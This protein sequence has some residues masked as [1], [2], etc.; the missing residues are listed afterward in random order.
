MTDTVV[1]SILYLWTGE[2]WL[3]ADCT[4]RYDSNGVSIGRSC[5]GHGRISY[6]VTITPNDRIITSLNLSNNGPQSLGVL[7]T[8]FLDRTNQLIPFQE[9][10]VNDED[11]WG[12][13][14]GR[15][16]EFVNRLDPVN[17]SELYERF[18]VISRESE[19]GGTA[20]NITD[21][22]FGE[23]V[24]TFLKSSVNNSQTEFTPQES[25]IE[26]LEDGIII[27]VGSR[28]H[29]GSVG[30]SSQ[31]EM[32]DGNINFVT[33]ENLTHNSNEIATKTYVDNSVRNSISHGNSSIFIDE[34]GAV[35]MQAATPEGAPLASFFLTEH[36]AGGFNVSGS[37][38]AS[39]TR[40]ASFGGGG[41]TFTLDERG[42]TFRH[43]RENVTFT[44]EDIKRLK[45]LIG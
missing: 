27:S 20:D 13:H 31:I 32:K 35:R 37:F 26:V 15:Y 29:I 16:W 2:E 24:R 42:Y 4:F 21:R 36:G 28:F 25:S 5:R 30:L 41:H 17:D 38:F 7:R 39:G 45:D 43:N 14:I 22:P 19:F 18:E 34:A 1:E 40:E 3:T 12:N 8:N 23:D 33:N 9:F 11:D 6:P 44:F 10:T